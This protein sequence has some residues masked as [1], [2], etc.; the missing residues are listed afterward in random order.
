MFGGDGD[1]LLMTGAGNDTLTG[2]NGNDTMHGGAS[3][4]TQIL[5]GGEGDDTY[6]CLFTKPRD[7]DRRKNSEG[8]DTLVFEDLNP[9]FDFWISGIERSDT[10]VLIW[11]MALRQMRS[12]SAPITTAT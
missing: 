7:L 4:G 11:G 2:G 6:F 5:R 9:G 10:L 12:T 8:T 3:E 1:D